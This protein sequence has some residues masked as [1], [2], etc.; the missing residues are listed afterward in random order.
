MFAAFFAR[1]FSF[2]DEPP[3]GRVALGAS[4]TSAR[5]PVIADG[6]LIIVAGPFLNIIRLDAI[7]RPAVALGR[8]ADEDARRRRLRRNSPAR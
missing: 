8:P 3:Q 2:D 6:V 1:C 7:R 4:A 5:E